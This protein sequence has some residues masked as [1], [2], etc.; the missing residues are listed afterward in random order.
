M[1]SFQDNNL[2]INKVP[3]NI[4]L[5]VKSEVVERY[6]STDKGSDVT[7]WTEQKLTQK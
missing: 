5:N 7:N 4:N 2:L 6:G 1:E 3:S